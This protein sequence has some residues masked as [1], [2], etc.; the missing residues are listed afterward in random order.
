MADITIPAL[1]DGNVLSSSAVSTALYDDGA[2]TASFEMING[3]LE[4]VNRVAG[5]D[6]KSSHIQRGACS[7][8]R[9]VGATVNMDSFMEMAPTFL[10]SSDEDLE[11]AGIPGAAQDFYLPYNCSLVVFSWTLQ[12]QG[13]GGANN[14]VSRIR[15]FL[16]AAR[17][18]NASVLDLPETAAGLR[19]DWGRVWTGHRLQTGLTKGWHSFSLRIAGEY[20]T[21]DPGVSRVRCRHL[22]YVYFK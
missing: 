4:N 3:R 7:G 9:T 13:V 1:A 12:A 18:A 21:A 15:P 11:Y 10:F 2:G 19:G 8:G 22:D 16:G 5:W 17:V 6:I 20:D 14:T